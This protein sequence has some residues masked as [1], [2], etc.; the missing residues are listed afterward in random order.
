MIISMNQIQILSVILCF[1]YG[2]SAQATEVISLD[3]EPASSLLQQQRHGHDH[4]NGHENHVDYNG[5][6][7][8]SEVQ[9]PLLMPSMHP[10]NSAVYS[11]LV[12]MEMDAEEASQR[13]HEKTKR[14]SQSRRKLLEEHNRSLK[15]FNKMR[16]LSRHERYERERFVHQNQK[17]EI[18]PN[19]GQLHRH[20]EIGRTKV[21]GYQASEPEA[22]DGGLY[23]EFHSVPLAQGYGTH[24]V[25][26]WVGTPTPQR[27]TLI[28]DTGSHHTAFPCKGCKNCGEKHHTDKYFDPD[29]SKTF[30]SLTCSECLWG[31]TT[32]EGIPALGEESPDM[33][34]ATEVETKGCMFQ[35]AYTEGSSWKAFQVQDVVFVGGKDMF[36]AAD[37]IAKRYSVDF[38]FGCQTYSS[39]LFV[40][41]LADGIMGL[42]QHDATLPRSMYNQGKLRN[43]IFGLCFRTEMVVSKKG[44]SAGV[45]TLGGIDRR[46]DSTP[47]VWA[48]NLARTGWFTVYVKKLYLRPGGGSSAKIENPENI[49]TITAD[50]FNINSGKGVILDSGTTDTYL[51]KSLAQPFNNAWKKI[52]GKPYTNLPVKLTRQQILKLPTI[53]VQLVPYDTGFDD[54]L[55]SPDDVIGLVGNTL[56]ENSPTDVIIAIPATHYMEYSPSKNVY[57]SRFYFTETRGGVLGANALQGHDVVFDWDYGRIGFAESSCKVSDPREEKTG[58]VSEGADARGTD[59]IL[60]DP[61]ITKAC[62]DTVDV[63]SC[64]GDN[65]DEMLQGVEEWAVVVEYPGTASGLK[66]EEVIRMKMLQD[67]SRDSEVGCTEAGLCTT[68]QTCQVAC[69][70]VRPIEPQQETDIDEKSKSVCPRGSWGACLESCRQA[71]VTSSFMTDGRCHEDP[72]KREERECHTEYCGISDPCIIPFVVHVILAFRGVVHSTWDENAESTIIDAFSDAIRNREKEKIFEPSD[73]ELLMIS[74]WHEDVLEFSASDDVSQVLG[75]KVVMEVHMY[76]DHAIKPE[77]FAEHSTARKQ[78]GNDLSDRLSTML[79]SKADSKKLSECKSSDIFQLAQKAHEIHFVLQ[80]DNFVESLASSIKLGGQESTFSPFVE[81]DQFLKDSKVFSSWTIKTEVGGGSV[82]DHE[83]DPY[84]NAMHYVKVT[85]AYFGFVNL[86]TIAY[87]CLPLLVAYFFSKR[88]RDMKDAGKMLSLNPNSTTFC[89]KPFEIVRRNFGSASSILGLRKKSS[90]DLEVSSSGHNFNEQTSRHRDSEHF[91][92]LVIKTNG[93][94]SRLSDIINN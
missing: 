89:P 44:I 91:P 94:R 90:Q 71:K 24:Y 10:Y 5:G 9:A 75:T 72:I 31:G 58:L 55:G 86:P 69:R 17:A 26:M 23:S 8:L 15:E 2:R 34:E 51:H 35:Q 18:L 28:V 74:P 36:S 49:I 46:L 20:L 64:T 14:S 33:A 65:P 43:R 21:D 7:R 16:H 84:P 68:K 76:N 73:V 60:Q 4:R 47:M 41:Q 48:R 42:S 62:I 53:L 61:V 40:S 30:R 92:G 50:L 82:Y 81:N 37:P 56:D 45:M 63:N 85:P 59:C 12:E 27:K 13:L 38:T 80:K 39:G 11:S 87:V 32:C 1:L 57:T 79:R 93:T 70:Y 22:L 78:Q 25:T 88:R 66:C 3:L 6:R 67:L 29:A 83:L 19:D 54:N 77:S 52:T